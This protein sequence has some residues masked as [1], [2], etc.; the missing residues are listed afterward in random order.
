[1]TTLASSDP[2]PSRGAATPQSAPGIP[3]QSFEFSG[4]GS[5]TRLCALPICRGEIDVLATGR[6]PRF[7]SS[8]CRNF[9]AGKRRHARRNLALAAHFRALAAE[10]HAGRPNG[11][12][13]Q[14][15]ERQAE[16]LEVRAAQLLAEIGEGPTTEGDGATPYQVVGGSGGNPLPGTREK[17]SSESLEAA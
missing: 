9:A 2:L 13:H 10:I 4:V 1:M 15:L 16:H 14:S 8:S 3:S 5:E 7:C 12:S 11:Y 6:P 17:H